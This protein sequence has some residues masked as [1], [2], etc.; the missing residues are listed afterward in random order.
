MS[1][2]GVA[3]LPACLPLRFD[4]ISCFLFFSSFFFYLSLKSH[5][6]LGVFFSPPPAAA[7]S[8]G[9]Q[10]AVALCGKRCEEKNFSVQ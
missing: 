5:L 9:R 1:I 3:S 2:V 6:I 8:F 4:H 10:V 7:A